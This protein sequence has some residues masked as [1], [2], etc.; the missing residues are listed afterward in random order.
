MKL[1]TSQL[2]SPP[3]A[4]KTLPTVLGSDLVYA[5]VKQI[6][7]AHKFTEMVQNLC[8]HMP[9]YTDSTMCHCCIQ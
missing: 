5:E 6:V 8:M 9:Y 7:Y 1:S 4:V 2:L 3:F